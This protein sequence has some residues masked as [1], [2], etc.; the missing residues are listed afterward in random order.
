MNTIKH[1]DNK[2]LIALFDQDQ[3]DRHPSRYAGNEMRV[4]KNDEKRRRRVHTILNNGGVITARDHYNSAM[5]FQHGITVQ[6]YELAR[7]LACESSEMQKNDDADWLCAAAI[8][9]LLVKSGKKQKFGTQYRAIQEYSGAN[10]TA[11]WVMRLYPY[12]GRTSD[13]TRALYSVSPIKE[14]VAMEGELRKK[15]SAD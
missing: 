6:D 15:I 10:M 11:K 7:T 4:A 8:D 14:L 13:V 5:I 12:D 3:S 2:I 9:R 1:N